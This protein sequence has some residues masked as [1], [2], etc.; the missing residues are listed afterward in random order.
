MVDYG[1]R[2]EAAEIFTRIMQAVITGLKTDHAFW[3]TY[4]AGTGRGQGERNTLNGLAPVGFLLKLLGLVQI[5][6]N[7]VIVDGMNPFSRS[8]T[9]QY[10]GTKV[11]FFRDRTQ[12]SFTNGQTI[13]VQG[14]G[15]HEISLP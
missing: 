8:I 7:R 13:S 4:N 1:Y 12:V 15:I 6:P 11:D 2:K 10:R 9:V 3:S 14:G 5:S